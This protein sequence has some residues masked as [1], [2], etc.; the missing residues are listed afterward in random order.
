MQKQIYKI[1]LCGLISLLAGCNSLS[2]GSLEK[3]AAKLALGIQKAYS[4]DANTAQRVS[5]I[6]IQNAEQYNINPLLMAALIRQ[7]SSY[8]NNAVS[9]SGAIGLTQ[10][11]PRFWQNTCGD[12]LFD[13]KINIHC[14]SYILAQY[15]QST[16]S[17]NKAL[18]YYNVGPTGYKA[19][20]KNKRQG[21][22]YA[23][24][25]NKHQKTLKNAL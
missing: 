10:V 6:I 17:W 15:Y 3:R 18:A 12:Q 23:K 16:N 13:E 2:G 4:V 8:R 19:S 9:P 22:K 20:W 14:G 24:S 11:L 21:K 7:E 5:P 25:V 1:I